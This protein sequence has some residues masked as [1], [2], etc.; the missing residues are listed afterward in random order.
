MGKKVKGSR[1]RDEDSSDEDNLREGTEDSRIPTQTYGAGDSS[2][3]FDISESIDMLSE[4][5]V[6]LREPSLQKII[7]FLQGS[8]DDENN[9]IVLNGYIETLTVHL[10]R[11]IRRPATASEGKLCLQLIALLALYLG[12]QVQ[13][14]KLN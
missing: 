13:I 8:H 10:T 5:K 3:S 11:M 12:T 14:I 4:K 1:R 7:K 2:G 9:L 6:N